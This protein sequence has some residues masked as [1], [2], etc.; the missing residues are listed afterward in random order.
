MGV[1]RAATL[2]ALV[3]SFAYGFA[4]R[5]RWRSVI[6]GTLASLAFG[7]TYLPAVLAQYEFQSAGVLVAAAAGG[8]VALALGAWSFRRWP[9]AVAPALALSAAVRIPIPVNRGAETGAAPEYLFL[10]VPLYLLTVAALVAEAIQPDPL[11]GPPLWKRDPLR[12]PVT[13]LVA[14]AALSTLWTAGQVQGAIR[15]A[16]FWLLLPTAYHALWRA[17]RRGGEQ[18]GVDHPA[19]ASP[20]R[21]L[22]TVTALVILGGVLGLVGI[23]QHFRKWL[24]FKNT[25]LEATEWQQVIF[26]VNAIFW[27]PNMFARFLI[28]AG[29]LAGALW[30]AARGRPAR[31]LA[32]GLAPMLAAF[33]FTYSRSGWLAA[34]VIAAMVVWLRVGWKKAVAALLVLTMVVAAMFLIIRAPTFRRTTM[35]LLEA[36]LGV[37]QNGRFELKTPVNRLTGGRFGLMAGGLAMYEARPVAGWGLGSFPTVYP[38]YRPPDATPALRESHNS[39]ITVAAE[40]GTVGLALLAWTLVVA[41]RQASRA[42][43]AARRARQEGG[44]GAHALAVA[45]AAGLAALLLHSMLYAALVE[46]PFTWVFLALIPLAGEGAA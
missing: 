27:D 34:V 17:M 2:V 7:A 38:D 19:L 3:A 44:D 42:V 36:T 29:L 32:L 39:V 15:L 35:Q 43:A 22:P 10:L 23:D 25:N 18:R 11:D 31:W 41:G 12:L 14:W 21:W 16:C 30:F 8:L 28:L 26:R 40:L 6:A 9:M 45:A 20:A 13:A 46:D 4:W 37:A 33:Y 1:V 5:M 24:I